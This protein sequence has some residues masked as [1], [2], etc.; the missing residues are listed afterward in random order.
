MLSVSAL[1]SEI[2]LSYHSTLSSANQ[3]DAISQYNLGVMYERGHGV[4]QDY[5]K[6]LELYTKSANQGYF[7]AQYNLGVVYEQGL[8]V[9]QDYRKAKEW[10]GKACDSGLQEGCN[11][12]KELNQNGF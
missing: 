7:A 3:G 4:R 12:Y 8:G 6:A 9:R 10:Y 1:G 2:G 11:A 5:Q